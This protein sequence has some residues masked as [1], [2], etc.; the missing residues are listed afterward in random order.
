[1]TINYPIEILLQI[2]ANLNIKD[3][4]NFRSAE[5]YLSEGL[6]SKPILIWDS[7][8]ES[9]RL[10]CSEKYAKKY[11]ITYK[12]LIRFRDLYLDLDYINDDRINSIL[13]N[14]NY[15]L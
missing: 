4:A 10:E 1:M 8:K 12:R 11:N 7:F 3:Y 6:P 14:T 15:S 2:S 9:Y 13:E 5:R